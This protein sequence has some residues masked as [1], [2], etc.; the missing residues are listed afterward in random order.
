MKSSKSI[1]SELL[2]QK[3]ESYLLLSDAVIITDHN[4]FILDVNKQYEVTT[5]YNRKTILGLKAGFLKSQL[6][7]K[8]THQ[9][10]KESLLNQQPW[11]GV[12]VNRKKT[13]ELW[14]SSITIT[15]LEIEGK[16]YYVGVFRELEQ[17]PQ[18]I[19][20]SEDRKLETQRE[21]LKVLAIS[22]EIR[23]PEI[24]QHLVRVQQY[25]QYLI[26]EYYNEHVSELCETYLHN[27]IHCS[28]LHDIGK[29][30]IPEGILYKPGALTFYE[31]QIIEMHPLLGADILNK[32]STNINNELI[33]SLEVAENII[34]YH[35][36][37]WDGTGYPKGLKGEEIPF[38]ARVI[39]IV[40]VFDALTS[41]RAYKDSWPL[42]QAITYIAEQK[43]IHFDPV[44]TDT[45]VKLIRKEQSRPKPEIIH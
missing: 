37:K 29:A 43:G 33:T 38:E 30:G 16:Y 32:M 45:F 31:R 34:L 12:L 6:T 17:L 4:H 39:A 18:G 25:T 5:G 24:E 23:D 42:E 7:P 27:I 19:Y 13:G 14:H 40:D 9:Q 10:L 36:E 41:R 28:I 26:D 44:L 2:P 3:L 11:S 1:N 22:C 35:H 20:L 8:T 15:P 21:L